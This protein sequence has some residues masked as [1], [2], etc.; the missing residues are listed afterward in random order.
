MPTKEELLARTQKPAEESRRLHAFHKG[1]IQ[2]FP[3][4]PIRSL[5]DFDLWYTRG[6]R[7]PV[8]T[9]TTLLAWC[10]SL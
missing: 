10:T 1:K 2:T 6:G 8:V 3:K 7:L 9:F 4:C 5:E